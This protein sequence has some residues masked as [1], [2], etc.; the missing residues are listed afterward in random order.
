MLMI[1]W[2]LALGWLVYALSVL[3]RSRR[4]PWVRQEGH[5]LARLL[6][7]TPAYLR[8]DRTLAVAALLV[9]VWLLSSVVVFGSDGI[10]TEDWM[11]YPGM[12][13]PEGQSYQA[14]SVDFLRTT[15]WGSASVAILARCWRT[16]VAQLSVLP[17]SALWVASFDTYYN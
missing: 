17:L 15:A 7:P 11:G 8:F 4:Q 1:G 12:M 14:A 10:F 5:P 13:D 16:A 3:W 6:L 2:A 9:D